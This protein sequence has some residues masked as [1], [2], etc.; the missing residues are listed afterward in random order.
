MIRKAGENR[1]MIG[2]CFRMIRVS[3]RNRA[4]IRAVTALLAL[5]SAAI[6]AVSFT[7]EMVQVQG[8]EPVI[9]RVFWSDDRVRFEYQ[10]QGV[11]MAKIFDS[12]QNRVVWLDTENKVY[13]QREAAQTQRQQRQRASRAADD[14]PYNPCEVFQQ[15][16]CIRL[17]SAII[18]DRNTDKWLITF[19]V[20]G[21]DEHMF[22]WIDKQYRIPIRQENPDGSIL[23]VR[24]V[25]GVEMNGRK[26][27]KVEML[28][29]A[30][31]GKRSNAIQWYDSELNVVV[32]QQDDNGTVEELRNIRLEPVSEDKFTIPEGYEAFSTRLSGPENVSSIIFDTAE[33]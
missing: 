26:V 1:R 25:D 18:N 31:D 5:Y 23:D 28:S 13:I 32:R 12:K 22:Q 3:G 9:A 15:A 2:H 19:D 6:Q 14:K 8:G 10:D 24:I 4:G 29:I 33:N 21:R 7:A 20:D 27:Y 16:Q 30:P 17:K 11:P